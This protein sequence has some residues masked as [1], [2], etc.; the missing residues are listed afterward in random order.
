MLIYLDQ[1]LCANV[2]FGMDNDYKCELEVWG[3]S[4]TILADRI[5]TAP[6]GYS[7]KISLKKGQ[8]QRILDIDADDTFLKSIQWFLKCVESSEA[9]EE[10]YRV[11][12][13][14]AELLNSFYNIAAEVR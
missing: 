5:F 10:N 6:S 13:R 9:R 2:S 4:G 14:Q 3:S 1:G 8:E 12:E 11:I 7:P